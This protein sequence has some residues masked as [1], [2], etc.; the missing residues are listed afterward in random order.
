MNQ[1]KVILGVCLWLG[2]R[3]NLSVTGL[4]IVFAALF[5]LGFRMPYIALSPLVLYFI[6]YLIMPKN[7]F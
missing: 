7:Q 4:R 2:N 5:L 1:E 6:L 3:F